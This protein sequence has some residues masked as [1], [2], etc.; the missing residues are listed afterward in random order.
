MSLL[1]FSCVSPKKY[2]AKV[3]EVEKKEQENERIKRQFY[4]AQNLLLQSSD[5]LKDVII[6]LQTKDYQL[7]S[8]QKMAKKTFDKN[9]LLTKE[10]EQKEEELT[11]KES[12]ILGKEKNISILK[13]KQYQRQRQSS[14]LQKSIKTAF[15]SL[16]KESFS[17]KEKSGRLYI[18]LSNKLLFETASIDINSEGKKA[19]QKLA[20]LLKNNASG[21]DIWVEGH[22]DNMPVTGAELPFKDNWQLSALRASVVTKILVENGVLPQNIV[23]AGHGEYLPI[24]SNATPEGKSKNRRIEIVLLP[25]LDEIFELIGK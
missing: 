18:S 13:N 17:V 22:T 11:K 16:N 12:E 23:A 9:N 2:K 10:L 20:S 25:K 3:A 6:D 1:I 19:L 5:S 15:S 8:L 4:E 14:E 7:D 21:L 24:S